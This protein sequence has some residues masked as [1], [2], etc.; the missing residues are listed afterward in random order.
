MRSFKQSAARSCLHPVTPP[1]RIV[2]YLRLASLKQVYQ[3]D[4]T[5]AFITFR[6]NWLLR[7]N[8]QA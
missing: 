8:A 1:V 4:R 5:G 7:G 6:R 2:L 3:S